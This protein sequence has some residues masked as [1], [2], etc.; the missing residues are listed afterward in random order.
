[1]SNLAPETTLG[2]G[3][4]VWNDQGLGSGEPLCVKPGSDITF[5][6]NWGKC[7]AQLL[8]WNGQEAN[9]T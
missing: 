7:S 1:M 4:E 8:N 9:N 3:K 5:S 6:R 2:F